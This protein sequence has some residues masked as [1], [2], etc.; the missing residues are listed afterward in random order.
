MKYTLVMSFL[1]LSFLAGCKDSAVD[2]LEKN[3]IQ[4]SKSDQSK[5]L[6]DEFDACDLTSPKE[7]WKFWDAVLS[8]E[9]RDK[10]KLQ[11]K[12]NLILFHH[13]WGTGIRNEFCLWKG[14]PL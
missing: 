1:V 11:T 7:T 8:A 4:I 13:G 2:N 3:E 6:S 12:E 10:V 14:G 5:Y 9:D